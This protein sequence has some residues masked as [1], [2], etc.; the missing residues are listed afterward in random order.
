M[1]KVSQN[2]SIELEIGDIIYTTPLFGLVI[3]DLNTIPLST[4]SKSGAC[5]TVF[6]IK[7]IDFLFIMLDQEKSASKDSDYIR[8]Y[9]EYFNTELVDFLKNYFFLRVGYIPKIQVRK[10]ST[11]TLYRRVFYKLE[12]LTKLSSTIIN[13]IIDYRS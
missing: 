4:Y 10:S 12:T 8:D 7:D 11:T 3:T 5:N 6:L 9:E 1:I 2:E 13:S